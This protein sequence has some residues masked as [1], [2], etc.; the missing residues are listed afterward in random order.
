MQNNSNG[1]S[2]GLALL[3]TIGVMAFIGL[4]ISVFEP[5]CSMSGCDETASEGERY[6]FLSKTSQK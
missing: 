4:I 5:R 6:C 1:V 3:L 2:T